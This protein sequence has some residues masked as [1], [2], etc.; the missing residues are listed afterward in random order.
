MRL[1]TADA[2][3]LAVAR[4]S[5]KRAAN[6]IRTAT[7]HLAAAGDV[8]IYAE[9]TCRTPDD[10]QRTVRLIELAMSEHPHGVDVVLVTTTPRP[11]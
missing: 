11:Q 3:A 7:H 2:A 4:R 9:T 10:L 6:A 8:D 1:Q 5:V